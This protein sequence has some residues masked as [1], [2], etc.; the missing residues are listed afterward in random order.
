MT[1]LA[2]SLIVLC[3]AASGAAAQDAPEVLS[4]EERQD[5][6][7]EDM[8]ANP[9]D[10]EIMFAYAGAALEAG[11][12]E[13]AIATLERMLI[14]NPDL[15]R[16]KLELG[17]A[18][19]R[20]GA[21]DVARTYFEDVMAGDPPP[22]VQAT[23]AQFLE[24]ADER[25]QVHRFSGYVSGG[26]VYSTNANLGPDDRQ[27]T[28][29]GNSNFVLDPSAL[30]N[31]SFGIRVSA[32][33]THIYDLQRPN[34]DVWISTARYSGLRYNEDSVGDYDVIDLQTGPR[35][36]LRDEQFG[37]TI[38]PFATG[39]FVRSAG[40]PLYFSG[41]VGLG[42][43]YPLT[44]ETTLF[45]DVLSTFRSYDDDEDYDGGYARISLAAAHALSPDTTLRG[46]AFY[47]RDQTAEGYTRNHEVGGRISLEHRVRHAALS[48]LDGPPTASVF[49]QVSGRWFDDPDAVV[50]PDETR[51]DV[52]LLVGARVFAPVSGTVGVALDAGYFDRSSSIQNYELDN[53]EVGASV[54]VSF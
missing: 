23:I 49:G 34:E 24:G 40:D 53:F 43:V 48:F 47:E 13:A 21:Y 7:F 44:T 11:D 3:L 29:L 19:Y 39:A 36:A 35:L 1:L 20:L 46:A 31:D 52:D 45:G 33:A 27:V 54:I 28:V 26:L 41:G 22:E 12:I 51:A 16:V 30:E 42:W 50:D 17:A 10:L 4:P 32:G 5:A 9:G 8:I 38:R 18:Y 14:F 15:P 2:R 6:L 37:P 25:T